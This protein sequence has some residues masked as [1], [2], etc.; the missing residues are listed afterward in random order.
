MLSTSPPPGLWRGGATRPSPL[1]YQARDEGAQDAN[2]EISPLHL[3][4]INQHDDALPRQ[5]TDL[6]LASSRY[7]TLASFDEHK[8]R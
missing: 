8:I 6:L 1:T 4:T 5:F 7:Q 3:V 2:G